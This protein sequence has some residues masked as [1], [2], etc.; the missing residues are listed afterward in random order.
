MFIKEIPKYRNKNKV[1]KKG[2]VLYAK[3]GIN[4]GSEFSGNHFCVVFEKNDHAFKDQLVVI[5]LTSKNNKRTIELE[6]HFLE[7]AVKQLYKNLKGVQANSDRLDKILDSGIKG[8]KDLNVAKSMLNKNMR[9]TENLDKIFNRYQRYLGKNTY[10]DMNHIIT[11]S[12]KRISRLN[13]MDPIGQIIL[14]QN[15]LDIIDKYIKANYLN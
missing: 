6:D 1:Y 2:V 11:I 15:S 7:L 9:D 8:K 3:F 14:S 10:I 5:P 12:K 4:I 13:N